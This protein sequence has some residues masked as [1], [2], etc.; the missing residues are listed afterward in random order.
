MKYLLLL[1][2]PIFY[3]CGNSQSAQKT[4]VLS[5]PKI[6]MTTT[7]TLT[8][9]NNKDSIIHIKINAH[10]LPKTIAFSILYRYQK[11]YVEI[12]AVHS[13]KIAA[14]L[15]V[16]GKNRNIRFNQIKMPDGSSDGPFGRS[17]VYTTRQKGNYTLII[18]KDNMADGTLAGE[19]KV[20]ISLP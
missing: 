11:V 14:Q 2:L 7:D 15:E 19:A 6:D 17:I 10:D 4:S 12:S 3:S 5:N 9:I 18:G 1:A 8:R 16:E 20:F 13:H